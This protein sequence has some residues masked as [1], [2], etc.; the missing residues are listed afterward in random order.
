LLLAAA[1]TGALLADFHF[2]ELGQNDYM[3]LIALSFV[4]FVIA[5]TFL[6]LGSKWAR[7]AMF[8]LFFLAFM[9][10]LPEAAVDLLENASKEASAEVANWLFLISGTPF[11]RNGTLFQLP[12]ITIAVA[13]ECSG[14]RS[15]LVLVI[16]SLLAAN[17]FLRTTWR[18]ALL[19]CA[20]IPLGLLRNG[21]RILVISLLCVHIGP[22]M[23]DSTIHRRGGPFFFA[24][25]LIPL[26]LLLWWLR[27]GEVTATR[28]N[29]DMGKA[30][31]SVSA[32]AKVI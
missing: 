12:G 21:L 28:R 27:R 2:A 4:C 31:K 7:S 3:T 29:S 26:F 9:I 18:R 20:V 15:S 24:A 5:G 14:I 8:P 11:L 32:D 16:T 10:P 13:K 19:V 17:M 25:S 30:P 1:G 6:F 22:E 23:I